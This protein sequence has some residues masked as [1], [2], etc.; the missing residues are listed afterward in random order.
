VKSNPQCSIMTRMPDKELMTRRQGCA[1]R[2]SSA[3]KQYLNTPVFDTEG[4]PQI[5]VPY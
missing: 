1:T 2:Q 3:Y 5:P 4:F